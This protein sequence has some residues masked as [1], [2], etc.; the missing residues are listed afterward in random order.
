MDDDENFQCERACHW[1]GLDFFYLSPEKLTTIGIMDVQLGTL[2]KPVDTILP[3]CMR[4]FREVSI[5]PPPRFRE[6]IYAE[7]RIFL[8]FFI[9]ISGQKVGLVDTGQARLI[10]IWY[11][12]WPTWRY[13]LSLHPFA[14][15]SDTLKLVCAILVH[16]HTS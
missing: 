5:A 8:I 14:A 13:L 9:E 11:T 4:G 3:R 15:S 16:L 1:T 7:A 10:A 2:L 6:R 12:N